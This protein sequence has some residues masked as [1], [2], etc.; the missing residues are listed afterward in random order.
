MA[1]SKGGGVSAT[2]GERDVVMPVLHSASVMAPAQEGK[3]EV[4][5]ALLTRGGV[6]ERDV[7]MPVL[8]LAA[9]EG[10]VEVVKALLTRGGVGW[11]N[12]EDPSG[13]TLLIAAARAGQFEVVQTLFS[14]NACPNIQNKVGLDVNLSWD[15]S[16]LEETR[17]F[18]FK[19]S[20]PLGGGYFALWL[21]H[22]EFLAV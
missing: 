12:G 22:F 11:A 9:Q 13:E 6:G 5:N 16:S 2:V 8:M 19:L 18:F 20:G 14:S 17:S 15:I 7:V 3:V 10:K 21:H 1:G 4:V